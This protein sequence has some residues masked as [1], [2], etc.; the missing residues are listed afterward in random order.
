MGCDQHA[1][2]ERRAPPPSPETPDRRGAA[3]RSLRSR[4]PVPHKSPRI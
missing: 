3:P 2:A 1:Q 4:H